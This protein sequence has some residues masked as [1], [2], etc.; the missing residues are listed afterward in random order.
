[1]KNALFLK[2][3]FPSCIQHSFFH[4]IL[5]LL[6]VFLVSCAYGKGPDTNYVKVN[7]KKFMIKSWTDYRVISLS[8][9]PLDF[10]SML[11]KSNI[12][13]P[14]VS[15]SQG[16][17]ASYKFITL[18]YSF[19]IPYTTRNADKYGSSAYRD[20]KFTMTKQKFIFSGIFR[21]Y[22]GFY[23]ES[24]T[25]LF[26]SWFENNPRPQRPD[27]TY[28]YLGM[29]GFWIFNNKKFSSDA[30]F[31]QKDVQYKSAFSLLA[32][33]DLGITQM[34]GDTFLIP[35][36]T[37]YEGKLSDMKQL[38]FYSMDAS[39]GAVYSWVIRHRVYISPIVFG[40]FGI[41]LKQYHKPE[42]DILGVRLL[43]RLNL[44][45]SMG[46]NSKNVFGGMFIETENVL[47]PETKILMMS[48]VLAINGFFGVKF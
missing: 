28:M 47:M 7:R 43:Y 27:I 4:I 9:T 45:L 33:G 13:I 44:R 21:Q 5:V 30:F 8:I 2:L 38:S 31:N 39:I 25:S 42:E 48:N 22:K 6:M 14:N 23:T 26:T 18:S 24:T 10:G 35:S 17:A 46:Y 12:Y 32:M 36:E 40:G 29:E 41:Q 11:L 16:I 34:K 15:T 1:M 37:G 3:R 20:V 19:K